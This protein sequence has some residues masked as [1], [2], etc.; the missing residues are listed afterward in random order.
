MHV[1]AET[2]QL[3]NKSVTG[4]IGLFRVNYQ[5]LSPKSLLKLAILDH[6]GYHSPVSFK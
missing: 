1:S 4:S 5:K 2:A 6:K 3:V